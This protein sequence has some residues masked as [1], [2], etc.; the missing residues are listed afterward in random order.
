MS[1]NIYFAEEEIVNIVDDLVKIYRCTICN[2]FTLVKNEH[3]DKFIQH[4]ID[5]HYEPHKLT[6]SIQ[7]IV[8][9][10]IVDFFNKKSKVKVRA[11]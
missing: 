6:K 5:N 4:Y 8:K 1:N 10:E 3:P 9:K 11:F 7:D 2:D